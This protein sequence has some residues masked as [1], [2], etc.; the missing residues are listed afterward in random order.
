ML[1]LYGFGICLVDLFFNNL[2]GKTYFG[3]EQDGD[4]DFGV[5]GL[6]EKRKRFKFAR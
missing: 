6:G 4:E 1:G 3:L 5:A 2:M